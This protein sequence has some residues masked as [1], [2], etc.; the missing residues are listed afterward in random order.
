MEHIHK[1]HVD[2]TNSELNVLDLKKVKLRCIR[3]PSLHFLWR[4][5]RKL[6]LGGSMFK[7]L[8]TSTLPATQYNRI[9]RISNI[10]EFLWRR[11]QHHHTT[12]T[13]WKYTGEKP[14]CRHRVIDGESQHRLHHSLNSP[15]DPLSEH[16]LRFANSAPYLFLELLPLFSPILL[17]EKFKTEQEWS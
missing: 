3:Q 6:W 1:D 7:Q 13:D 8:S 14:K 17:Q 15:D 4:S 10:T 11:H 12:D 9:F 5:S 2:R 16:F